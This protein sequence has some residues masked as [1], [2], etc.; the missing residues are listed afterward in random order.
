MTTTKREASDLIKGD[1]VIIPG[2]TPRLVYAV[3][4]CIAARATT[5]VLRDGSTLEHH[6]RDMIEVMA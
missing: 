2:T 1:L 5:I 3:E 6:S 4:T